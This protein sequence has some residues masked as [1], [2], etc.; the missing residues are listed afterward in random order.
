[1]A[2]LIVGRFGQESQ[3]KEDSGSDATIRSVGSYGV[4]LGVDEDSYVAQAQDGDDPFAGY[5][6]IVIDATE[7]SAE[8]LHS[9]QSS[10]H[11]VYSYLNIGSIE[12]YRSYYGEFQ[13]KVLGSYENWPDEYW[14]DVSDRDWQRLVGTTIPKQLVDKGIDGFFIDNCDVYYEYEKDEIFQGLRAIVHSIAS[15]DLPVIINGGD[16]FVTGMIG[17]GEA[18]PF[19]GVNQECVLTTIEDYDQ[20]IFGVQSQEEQKYFKSYLKHCSEAGLSVALLEYTD[21][22]NRMA[23]I[24]DYAKEQGYELYISDN[25]GLQRID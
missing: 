23:E 13:D 20:D 1:M 4:F 9:L 15:Y 25:V 18:L 5:E 24:R 2:V 17:Q 3:S 19:T 6:T 12:T 7:Y 22:E 11:I 8:T 16:T 14:M 21:D 10:G